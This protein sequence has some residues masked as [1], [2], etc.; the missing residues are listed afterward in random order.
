VEIDVTQ[1]LCPTKT[2]AK[3]NSIADSSA[4]DT[5]IV[6]EIGKWVLD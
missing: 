1:S 3:L 5:I 4:F 6:K 2:P